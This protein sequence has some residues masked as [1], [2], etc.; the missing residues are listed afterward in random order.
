M[1]TVID[2]IRELNIEP[3]KELS[4]SVGNAVRDLY[5]RRHGELPQKA[6]RQKTNEEGSHC[7]A[8]Y[9]EEMKE[10]IMNIILEHDFE[11]KRQGD[12]F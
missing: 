8:I 7:F 10:E 2:V 5:E 12:L 6:L 9:P 11:T 4:W 3:T 1:I